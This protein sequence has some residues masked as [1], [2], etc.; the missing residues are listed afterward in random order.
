M[1]GRKKKNFE[2]RFYEELAEKIPR[3]PHVLVCLGELYTRQGF[4][5]EGLRVD[6]RL[7]RL[8]PRDPTVR[9]NLACSHA[10]MGNI[11]ES[12]TELRRAV[13]CG[14]E[15]FSLLREDPDLERLRAYPPFREYITRASVLLEREKKGSD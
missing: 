1:A 5:R 15:D 3:F 9:Y 10:L 12:F 14:Y 6:K 13:L 7:V 4:Y 8:R 11:P 2:L